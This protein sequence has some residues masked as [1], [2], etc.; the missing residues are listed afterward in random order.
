MTIPDLLSLDDVDVRVQERIAELEKDNQALRTEILEYKRAENEPIG[1]KDKP[2][3]EIIRR[4]KRI[5]EGV[6]KIFSIALQ[7]KTEED[8]GYKSLSVAL[9]LTC[10][11]IGFFSLMDDDGLLH[12]IAIKDMGWESCVMHDKTGYR[13]PSENFVMHDLYGSII[14]SSGKGFL[15]NDLPSHLDSI[16]LP[17]FYPQLQSFLG[18]PL[19]LGGK[20]RGLLAVA[21]GEDGY[22]DEQQEDLEAIVPVIMEALQ[23]I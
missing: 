6:S 21:N 2:K 22:S 5:L 14:N 7:A 23:R 11:Q 18:V 12:D 20:I 19:F 13:R 9:E 1:L 10:S 8:L 16:G 15:T 4:Y 17:H 3:A